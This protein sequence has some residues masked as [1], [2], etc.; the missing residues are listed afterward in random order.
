[1]DTPRPSPRPPTGLRREIAWALA[2]KIA[3]LFVLWSLFFG[4]AHRPSVTDRTMEEI[5]LDRR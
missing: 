5:I 4:P 1:M 2:A 3:A